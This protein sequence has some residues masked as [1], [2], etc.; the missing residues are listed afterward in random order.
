MLC[1]YGCGQDGPYIMTTRKYCCSPRY[2]S[3]PAVRRRNSDGIAAAH[4]DGRLSANT[5]SN[6]G[7]K[8]GLL[9]ENGN[10]FVYNGKGN[11]KGILISERGHQCQ[12][13]KNTEWLEKPITLELEH[14]DGDR[15]NNIRENLLLLCPNCHSQ[16]PTWK[17]GQTKKTGLQKHSDDY[18]AEVISKSENINQVLEKL[19]LR[20]G[21]VT[22]IIRVMADRQI[23]FMGR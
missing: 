3:C 10:T 14:A 5:L 2:S 12:S 17:R 13:C 21:S 7:W 22:T 6:K 1:D 4:K 20:Y 11:H 8:K 18:I 9:I 19:D 15:K 16:T 23:N